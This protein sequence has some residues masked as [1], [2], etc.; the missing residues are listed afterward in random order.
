MIRIMFATA[1]FS[2]LVSWASAQDA[3]VRPVKTVVIEEAGDLLRRQFFGN[4][5]AKETVDLAFQVSGQIE[6]FPVVEGSPVG[7]GA[8]IAQLDL[9]PFELSLAQ[10]QVQ[11]DQ[12]DRN[13]ARMENL[14]A[15]TVSEATVDDARA[16]ADLAAIAVRDAEYALEHATLHAPFDGLIATRNTANFTT[17]Q[18]G[19][20]VVRVHDVSEWRVEIGVP[21]VLFRL[22]GEDPEVELYGVFSGSERKI[23]LETREFNAEASTVGQTFNITLAMLDDPGPGVLPGSSITVFAALKVSTARI[24]VPAS[25]V[26]VGDGGDTNVMVF[27]PGDGDMGTVRRVAVTLETGPDGEFTVAEGLSAGEE[28]VVAG[29]HLLEDGQTVRRFTGF[30]N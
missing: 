14:S 1:L 30:A 10:A 19:T 25:S 3:P 9:E 13:L 8:L 22:A 21:E 6:A 11:K 16:E 23:P 29:A 18:A 26:V 24:E 17:V 27:E 5:V 2:V 4:V 7:E 12:A 20:P 15:A 28:L